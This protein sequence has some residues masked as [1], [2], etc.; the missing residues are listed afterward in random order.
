MVFGASHLIRI[1]DK[2]ILIDLGETRQA[3]DAFTKLSN[4]ANQHILTVLIDYTGLDS[5]R[6]EFLRTEDIFNN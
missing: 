1:R 3:P 5:P 4:E 6:F 2:L